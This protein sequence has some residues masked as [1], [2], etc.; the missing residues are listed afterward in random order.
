[1]NKCQSYPKR[2]LKTIQIKIEAKILEGI[3]KEA[4]RKP[5]QTTGENWKRKFK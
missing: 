3:D 1:M 2:P 5:K 4:K